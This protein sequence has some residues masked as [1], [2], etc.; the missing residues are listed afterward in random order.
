VL[1]P[2]LGIAAIVVFGAL[3]L[4]ACSRL[5][6]PIPLTGEKA[7]FVG[8][9]EDKKYIA[10]ENKV[11]NAVLILRDD[12]GALYKTCTHAEKGRSRSSTALDF[13]NAFVTALDGK[14]MRLSAQLTEIGLSLNHN[15]EL[16]GPP[17][18]REGRWYLR[19]EG[20]ELRKLE[21]GESSDH[22]TWVCGL[23]DDPGGGGEDENAEK[24]WTV[25]IGAALPSEV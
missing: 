22:E 2:A 13:N 20:R 11:D 3:L 16:D 9:W 7:V 21:A 19:V 24:D 8:T 12:G 1:K 5:R 4:T 17:V 14:R 15:L 23:D 18:Q 10:E 6:D 25:R